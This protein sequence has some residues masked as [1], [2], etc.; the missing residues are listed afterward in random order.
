MKYFEP[1]EY[2]LEIQRAYDFVKSCEKM[3][4]GFSCEVP[5]DICFNHLQKIIDMMRLKLVIIN[6]DGSM[7]L[8]RLRTDS[9]SKHG[10]RQAESGDLIAV[11]NRI[12]EVCVDYLK[13]DIDKVNRYAQADISIAHQNRI[14]QYSYLYKRL[15]QS[16]VFRHYPNGAKSALIDGIEQLIEKDFLTEIENDGT[17]G[18]GGKIYKIN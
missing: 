10:I 5:A 9:V 13:P 14:I 18:A 15:V 2:A 3:P 11:T 7:E 8:Y 6:H 1:S 17:M 4:A 12:V 16:A